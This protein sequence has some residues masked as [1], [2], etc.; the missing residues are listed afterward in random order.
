VSRTVK[1]LTR[2]MGDVRLHLIEQKAGVWE[3][4]WRPLQGTVFGESFSHV[5]HQVLNEGLKGWTK[6]LVDAL[7]IPPEGALRKI[8]PEARVCYRRHKCPFYEAKNCYPEAKKMPWCFEADGVE[9]ATVRQQVTRSIEY[10]RDRVYL[11]VIREET[12]GHR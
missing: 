2:E 9:D 8:P 4:E 10:W 11:V 12:D 3:E 6:P 7:S 5:P 1:M